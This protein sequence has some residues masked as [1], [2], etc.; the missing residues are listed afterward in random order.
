MVH[1]VIAGGAGNVGREIVEELIQ[2]G[3][4]KITVFSRTDRPDLV[5]EGI[6]VKVVNYANKAELTEALEGV[7]TVLSFITADPENT[8]QTNLINAS[9][10]AGVRRFAPSE[11]ALASKSGIP[12]YAYKDV[13]H[14]YLKQ[15]KVANPDF[16]FCLFQPNFFQNYLS[17]PHKSAKHMFITSIMLDIQQKKAL[18]LDDG[19]QWTVITSVEDVAKVVA[20]AIDYPGKWPETGGIVG[21]RIQVKDLISLAQKVRGEP[22]TVY[23]VKKDAIDE[24]IQNSEWLPPADH[25]SMT[26]E[27]QANL[28]K[29]LY[30]DI[31]RAL[32]RGAM[33]V[34]PTWNEL[35]PDFKFTDLEGFLNEYF[36][37]K[38]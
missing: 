37:P 17:Y 12:H 18:Q 7:N 30:P 21:T 24:G 11:W 25:P 36:G 5:K 1:V 27:M 35:L 16:E 4:H 26:P 32:D 9:I 23:T 33:D 6:D 3:K 22:F 34:P 10:A 31:L 38:A 14:E 8:A 13:V 15:V 2:Q 28:A 20:L 29:M 19:A